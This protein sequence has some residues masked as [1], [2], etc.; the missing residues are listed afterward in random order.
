V[1]YLGSKTLVAEQVL[2][3]LEPSAGDSFC[4]P[5]GGIA[6]VSAIAKRRGCEV[7]TG[8]VLLCPYS[9]QVARIAS[10]R[11]PSFAGLRRRHGYDSH[12]HVTEVLRGA[13]VD[14]GWL[15]EE[16]SR[17][18]RFFTVENAR[19]IE[20]VRQKI[21]TWVREGLVTARETAVLLASLVDSM[22]RVANT[23][24]TYYAHLKSYSRKARLP[25]EFRL[26]AP[27]PGSS[28]CKAHLDRAEDLVARKSWDVLYLDPPYNARSYAAY[29]H[30][31]E[32][33]CRLETPECGG[34]SGVPR[35]AA[36]PT[37]DFNRPARA[38]GALAKV[39]R[40][41]RSGR[42]AFHYTGDG[43]IS[44]DSAREL[45][46]PFGPVEE[47]VLIAP[48]YTTRNRPRRAEHVLLIA[49]RG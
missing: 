46:A 23:A 18:R 37:S 24:G 21:A 17:K 47:H 3:L 4:D 6:T 38:S 5:F 27:V 48:G 9:F 11:R 25:F 14:S 16:F 7:T 41:A 1:R 30:L 28:R 39:L 12:A 42:V 40:N 20:G 15:I 10:S 45:M 13:T 44:L 36:R 49:S 31:P 19:A 26:I 2:D 33:I 35:S 8:D 32:S 29:Y 22:D 43:L 34:R